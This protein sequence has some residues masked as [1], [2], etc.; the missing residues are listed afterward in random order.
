MVFDGR[1]FSGIETLGLL[2]NFR[3][4]LKRIE[5]VMIPQSNLGIFSLAYSKAVKHPTINPEIKVNRV[6]ASKFLVAKK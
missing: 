5:Y 6:A 2:K 3:L 4:I 1:I